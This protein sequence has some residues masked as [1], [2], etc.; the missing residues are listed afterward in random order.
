M[1]TNVI[2]SRTL[3]ERGAPAEIVRLGRAGAFTFLVSEPILA[4]YQKALS[5]KG[6]QARYGYSARDVA[7]E[8]RKLR[9]SGEMVQAPE[10]LRVVPD[11]PKDDIFLECAAAGEADYIVSGDSHLLALREYRGIR[12]LSPAVFLAFLERE[13]R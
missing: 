10:P 8:I 1:D 13:G 4:E 12:I 3:S 5:Y 9:K 2:V 7:R 6:V 11:D